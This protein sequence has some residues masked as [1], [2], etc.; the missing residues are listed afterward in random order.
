MTGMFLG[1]LIAACWNF[2]FI[3]GAVIGEIGTVPNAFRDLWIMAAIAPV[4]GAVFGAAGGMHPFIPRVGRGI[5]V[6]QALSSL[7]IAIIS[8]ATGE[9]RYS[10]QFFVWF[11][12]SLAAIVVINRVSTRQYVRQYVE[13]V[14][15]K[16]EVVEAECPGCHR[17]VQSLTGACPWC[18]TSLK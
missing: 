9:A 4:V 16:H 8:L 18:G 1:M 17:R 6:V 12:T 13:S 3:F 5:F 2:W 7:A 10:P 11:V 14:R 15:E